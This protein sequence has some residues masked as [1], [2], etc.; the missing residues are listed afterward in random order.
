MAILLCTTLRTPITHTPSEIV[1]T[2]CLTLAVC[3]L[4]SALEL[5]A[6]ERP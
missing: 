4:V 2:L 6:K 1:F 3:A 5:L